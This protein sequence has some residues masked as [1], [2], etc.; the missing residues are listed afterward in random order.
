MHKVAVY[1]R[2]STEEQRER[3]SIDNQIDFAKDYC[4]KNSLLIYKSYLDN[5]ISGSVPLEE[6]PEGRRLLEDAREGKFKN[7]LIWK[8]DRLG[9]DTKNSLVTA[10][11]L[12][13]LDV[14]IKSMT[15][16]F[17][18]ST[19]MG[20]FMFTQLASFAKLERDNIRE[21]SIAGTNR[22]AKQ[23]K[24]LGGIV[25]YGY[26]VDEDKNLVVNENK[27]NNLNYSEADVIRMI[28]EWIGKE[29]LSTL[30][31][32]K[33]LNAMNIPTHY[34]KDARKFVKPAQNLKPS[35]REISDSGKR[36]VNTSGLWHPHRIG[37]MVKNTT[38]M[39][40]HQYG[41]RSK[42][43][44]EII[45]REVNAIVTPELWNKAQETLKNNFL[46]AKRN[47]KR[48]YLLRGLIKCCICGRNLSG[49]YREPT[50]WYRCNG[51]LLHVEIGA[52]KKVCNLKSVKAEWIENLVWT[53][54][55]D[56]ILNPVSL[57]T[58]INEKLKDFE[59]EKGNYFLRIKNLKDDLEKKEDERSNILA[60]YRK[61]LIT[62]KDVED[63]L[64]DVEKDKN[65]LDLMITDIKSKMIGDFSTEE[66]IKEIKLHLD[67]F[68]IQLE[69]KNVSFEL[70]RKIIELFV[71]DVQIHLTKDN[72]HSILI[73]TIPFREGV[74][75]DKRRKSMREVDTVYLRFSDNNKQE[76]VQELQSDTVNIC[77]RFPFLSTSLSSIVDRTGRDSLQLQALELPDMLLK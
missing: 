30:E 49:A 52:G 2:V 1:C 48:E 22:I 62:M 35:E 43:P 69:N 34:S 17:D 63:Q 20:E 31:V 66:I 68:K 59:K 64:R 57:E 39:G 33:R 5:G 19:P 29:G 55:K 60:L 21:R 40:I 14:G 23:G 61:G 18:T 9:R 8:I 47:T 11:L 36:K 32:A 41:K 74:N 54:I 24:W 37:N 72:K 38:Y 46:W 7:I 45:E 12:K 3:Q 75:L 70:K 77:Y 42:K 65:E 16:P 13:E 10:H 73:D 15:E 4:Q 51:K 50:A 25:A 27:L 28:Y 71:K 53:D 44:R 6:R 26:L 76:K 67:V 58:V 56:W